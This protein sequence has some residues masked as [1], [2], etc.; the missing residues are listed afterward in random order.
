MFKSSRAF[1]ILKYLKYLSNSNNNVSFLILNFLS[2]SSGISDLL[3]FILNVCL[4]KLAKDHLNSDIKR[5]NNSHI[6]ILSSKHVLFIARLLQKQLLDMGIT[7]DICIGIPTKGYDDGLYLVLCPQVFHSL[8]LNYIAFQLEQLAVNHHFLQDP[9]YKKKLLEAVAVIDYS[10][11]NIRFLV[12][13]GFPHERLFYLPIFSKVLEKSQAEYKYDVLFY[14]YVNDRRKRILN[15]LRKYFKITI[16]DDCFGSEM[17]QLIKESKVILNIHGSDNGMVESARLFECLSMGKVIVS[18]T[19]FDQEEYNYLGTDII[20]FVPVGNV[21]LLKNSLTCALDRKKFNEKVKKLTDG[22][23]SSRDLFRFN[24]SRLFLALGLISLDTFVRYNRN[25]PPLISSKLTVC[26]HYAVSSNDFPILRH[27]VPQMSKEITIKYLTLLAKNQNLPHLVIN[28]SNKEERLNSF[29][30]LPN[31]L[32]MK[33]NLMYI[34]S[35]CYDEVISWNEIRC[36]SNPEKYSI[37]K[38]FTAID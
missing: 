3:R 25:N 1:R 4:G 2:R 22:L 24:L 38:L 10:L 12:E 8:P 13:S 35:E 30:D 11:S 19:G 7:S 27:F 33:G 23:N 20:T 6:K 18:E 16:A 14:G 34:P 5:I 31:K 29:Q 36:I 26:D 21:E 32:L 9:S 28:F 15:T 17:S 37:F